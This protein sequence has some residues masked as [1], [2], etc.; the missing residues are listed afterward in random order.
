MI[1]KTNKQTKTKQF[2]NKLFFKKLEE[3]WKE[4]FKLLIKRGQ[5]EHEDTNEI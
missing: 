1:K 2:K 5:N 3:A 4:M